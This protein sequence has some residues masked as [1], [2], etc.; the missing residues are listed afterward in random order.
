[1]AKMSVTARVK[2]GSREWSVSVYE[3]K[4]GQLP[5]ILRVKFR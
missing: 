5:T 4:W 1:M 3:R 2:G